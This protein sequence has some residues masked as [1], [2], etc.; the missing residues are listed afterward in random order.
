MS[1]GKIASQAGHAYVGAAVQADPQLL[2][3]YHADFPASPG[4]KVCLQAKN[5][6]AIMRARDMAIE[7]GIP[8]FLVVDSGCP[9]FFGGC[10]VVTALGLGPAT[11]AQIKHITKPFKLL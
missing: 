11:K 4:T 6:D 7:A 1:P 10:P 9:N 3:E 8:H 5:L 2:T